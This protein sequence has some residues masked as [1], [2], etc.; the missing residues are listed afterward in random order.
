MA[1]LTD[2]KFLIEFLGKT[3]LEHQMQIVVEAGFR[4]IS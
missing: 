3:L 1:P 4:D 2:D